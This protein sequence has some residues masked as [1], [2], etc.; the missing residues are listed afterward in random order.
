MSPPAAGYD[1]AAVF[2]GEE[3]TAVDPGSN[4]LLVGPEDVDKRG[5]GLDILATGASDNEG[6]L[7]IATEWPVD[8][9][10]DRYR[11]RAASPD[12]SA[13]TIIDCSG[14]DHDHEALTDEQLRTVPSPASLTELG[15]SF[16]HYDDQRAASFSGT[17]VLFD[18]ITSLLA[19]VGEERVFEFVD[20]FKGRFAASGYFGTWLI[21][22]PAN[23]DPTVRKFTD[24]FDIVVELR[25][26]EDGRELRV[27]GH[28]A[29]PTDWTAFPRD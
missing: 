3:F 20:A 29:E 14:S 17:R 16:V 4:I 25:Q 1:L 22:A 23:D 18:S 21:D 8:E 19:H 15:I 2:P 7:V 24:V 26:G 6:S 9:I 12:L 28:T 11:E 13:L 10:V 27:T 5:L